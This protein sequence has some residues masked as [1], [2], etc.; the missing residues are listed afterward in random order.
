MNNIFI[1]QIYYDEK[2][3]GNLDPRFIPLDN[4]NGPPDWFEF[5][6][7][8]NYLKNADLEENAWYGFL[9]P[10]FSSKTG[11]SASDVIGIISKYRDQA[12][13]A[14]FS[15]AWDQLAYF[16]NPF[17]Q[18]EFRHPGL[19]A[20]SQ[21][22][23]DEA[24]LNINL[25]NLITHSSTAV[26]SN[27]IIAKPTYWKKWLKIACQFYEFSQE[28]VFGETSYLDS[29]NKL[30]PMKTFIQE[31]LPSIVLTQN[32]F[33]TLAYDFGQ[34][35]P[36]FNQLFDNN[37]KTRKM[38]QACDLLKEK[39]ADTKD[40]VYL[41]MYLKIRQDIHFKYSLPNEL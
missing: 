37:P 21:K 27:F 14:L 4:R 24:N 18:G 17:E 36:I 15:P 29:K 31:R 38:L 10:K 25:K 9:S 23:I 2:S 34:S 8:M 19:L 28:N 7:I 26:F 33:K 16:R 13:V 1:H 30:G 22:F 6:P 12:N 5:Y 40:E 41:E 39:Y 35:A 3:M 20:L 11:M 32:H